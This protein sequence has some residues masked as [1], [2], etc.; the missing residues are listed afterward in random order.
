MT[1]LF[2]IGFIGMVCFSISGIPQAL[3]S[4]RDGHS[5]GM[6]AGTIW[7]WLI[8][9]AAYILY[10]LANYATDPILLVNYILNFLVVAVIAWYKHYPRKR[11]LE[12][13]PIKRI[14]NSTD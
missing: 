6:A 10:T 3:K 14:T 2:L 1:D 11:A 13:V 5:D 9:E 8:G 7:L 12:I 4:F